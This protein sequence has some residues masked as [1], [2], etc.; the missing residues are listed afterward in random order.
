[1]PSYY[2]MNDSV[3]IALFVTLTSLT[4]FG[5]IRWI[6]SYNKKNDESYSLLKHFPFELMIIIK[7]IHKPYFQLIFLCISVGWLI[8]YWF[9]FPMV[10]S[11]W[12]I[13]LFITLTMTLMMFYLIFTTSSIPVERFIWTTSI[14]HVLAI[15][16]PLIVSIFSFTSPYDR[17]TTFLP[18][19]SGGTSL[20]MMVLLFNPMLKRWSLLTAKKMDQSEQFV[21]PSIFIMALYQWIYVLSFYW[22]NFIIFIEFLV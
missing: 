16:L 5:L 13:P 7:W 22:L 18:W 11:S 17:F 21:R 14:A 9:M 20:M 12:T 15:I 19:V 3:F 1:M 10:G 8:F 2:V 6:Q 4:L